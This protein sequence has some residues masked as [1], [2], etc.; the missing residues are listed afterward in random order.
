MKKLL[1]LLLIVLLAGAL[2][3]FFFYKRPQTQSFRQDQAAS[4]QG[5][6][7]AQLAMAQRYIAGDMVGKDTQAAAALYE[8]AAAQGQVQATYELAQIYLFDSHWSS[9]RN[10]GL[11]YLKSAAEQGYAPA[12]YLLG[13]LYFSGYKTLPSNQVQAVLW[14]TEAARQHNQEA[15]KA[16]DDFYSSSPASAQQIEQ[17]NNTLQQ[18][19]AGDKEALWQAG[20]WFLQ[21]GLLEQNTDKAQKYLDQLAQQGDAKASYALFELY[22]APSVNQD[23]FKAADYLRRAANSGL[24]QAQYMLGK[25]IYEAAPTDPASQKTALAWLNRAAQQKYTDALYLSALLY[26]RGQ[27]V[28]K[29]LPRAFALFQQ[30]AEQG[31]VDAQYYVGKSYLE[32]IGVARNKERALRWLRVASWGGHQEAAALLEQASK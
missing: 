14:W 15:Q 21:G 6:A 28:A 10:E 4:E 5:D 11:A 2:G 30:A 26:W 22:S 12:Q 8:Q 24:A 9:K 3:Y 25:K 7:Q 13:N 18:A 27:G 23:Q 16:L 1:I 20:Q 19:Q 31:N 17:I 32:G 29:N